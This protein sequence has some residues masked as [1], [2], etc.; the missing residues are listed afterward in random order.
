MRLPNVYGAGAGFGFSG[1]EGPA[2]CL[3]DFAGTLTGDRI[4]VCFGLTARRTLAFELE[5]GVSQIKYSLVVNDTLDAV[6][7]KGAE[8]GRLFFAMTEH[9]ALA[10][11]VRF[12]K[13]VVI[14]E[15]SCTS[16]V[17]DGCS[18]SDGPGGF[19]ALYTEEGEETRF[20]FAY[21]PDSADA[22]IRRAK[23]A[24]LTD[25]DSLLARRVA[26]FEKLP[27]CPITDEQI[28][29]VYYKAFSVLKYNI[30]TAEG[31]MKGLW[32][33][34]DRLPHRNMWLWDSC[35]HTFG[36]CYIDENLAARAVEAVLER[37][38][39]DGFIPLMMTPEYCTDINQPPYCADLTQPPLLAWA[40][41][42]C[43]KRTG[44][45]EFLRRC[46]PKL[47][48]YLEWNLKNRDKNNNLLCE[49][50]VTGEPLCRS[51]ES[52]MDNSPRFDEAAAMDAP[53]FSCYMKNECDCLARMQ[54]ALG[55]EKEAER[56]RSI[57]SK[58]AAAVN[59]LLWNE[60][61]GMYTDRFPDGRLS[62]VMAVSGFMPL[63]AGIATPE[64]AGRLKK[65]ALDPSAFGT[66][67]PLPSVSADNKEYC[68][69]M[70]RGGVW[71]NMVYMIALGFHRYGMADIAADIVQKALKTIARWYNQNGAIYEFYHAED[72]LSPQTLA[73]KGHSPLPVDMRRKVVSIAD[74]N[75]TA[76]MY[77]ALIN[78]GLYTK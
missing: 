76:A 77:V 29:R 8:E 70:W 34:P 78:E 66:P 37:Q 75:W 56:S 63:W 35:F 5:H 25:L 30:Q 10:G 2:G 65:L 54:E 49:W 69:D 71:M 21:D 6:L 18:V 42:H 68:T 59:D 24:I 1:F 46:L 33:T 45:K 41:E 15:S 72:I 22:A 60:K 20:A 51:G 16:F 17:R 73:R 32:T 55:F 11:R 38:R 64:R 53:D 28:E 67:V 12:A 4:G 9:K 31:K 7:V 48:A 3:H 40:V 43:Y 74:F 23:V 13:P 57:A 62:D 44:D 47:R 58:I 50:Y 14:A 52:G 26:F 61:I 19:T 36:L 27:S 39:E